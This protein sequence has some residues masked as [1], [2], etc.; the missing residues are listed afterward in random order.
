MTEHK[1][2]AIA[3]LVGYA[4]ALSFVADLTFKK[5]VR[6]FFISLSAYYPFAV[7]IAS[8]DFAVYVRFIAAWFFGAFGE[9]FLI[10]LSARVKS[11]NL[12][13]ILALLLKD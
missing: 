3:F 12:K 6:I 5:S 11:A 8:S 2:L 4:S 10:K 7:Y 13:K 9:V 1:D